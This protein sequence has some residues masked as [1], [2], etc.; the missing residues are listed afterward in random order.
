MVIYSC[1]T[2]IDDELF[3]SSSHF[4]LW[5]YTTFQKKMCLFLTGLWNDNN[6]EEANQFKNKKQLLNILI[7]CRLLDIDCTGLKRKQIVWCNWNVH[8]SIF[9]A[10]QQLLLRLYLS[11]LTTDWDIWISMCIYIDIYLGMISKI[12]IFSLSAFQCMDMIKCIKS[13]FN[14]TTKAIRP[15]LKAYHEI[16]IKWPHLYIIYL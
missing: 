13:H 11:I 9:V 6:E 16:D 14:L 4:F 8:G 3:K 1:A 10:F 7:L 5:S 12:S 15:H 2:V